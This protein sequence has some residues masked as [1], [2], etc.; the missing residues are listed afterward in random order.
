MEAPGGPALTFRALHPTFGAECYG[1]DFSQP[2]PEETISDI[3]AAMARYGVL[4]FRRTQLDDAGHIT[5]ARQFGELDTSTVITMPWAKH[6]LAPHKELTD[7]GNIDNK[8][9]LIPKHS[10]AFQ[11]GRANGLFH[12]DCSFHARRA[13][14]SILRAHQ[15]PPKGTGG[16]TMFAD[17]RTAYDDLE[18]LIKKDM[19][20][21]V[22]CH[23][24]M[25]SKKIAAP[26]YTPFDIIKADEFSMI[27]QSEPVIKRLL[28]H[29]SQDKYTFTVDWEDAG[30]LVIWDN[31]CVMHRACGGS[32]QGQYIRDMRRAT[33]YDDS[34]SAWGLDALPRTVYWP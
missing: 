27:R 4:V 17:T 26:D 12:V 16:G 9:R 3:R 29:A 7:V 34:S 32:F 30:D 10:M 15:L 6:R 2:V 24:S 1:I 11:G 8:G 33:V 18:D 31:T 19:D 14:Y 25:H 21:Y 20:G 13:G 28:Q 22:L 5:F 23:S